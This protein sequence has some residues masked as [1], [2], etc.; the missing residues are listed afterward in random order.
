VPIAAIWFAGFLGIRAAIS[1]S[2]ST[3]PQNGTLTAYQTLEHLFVE[4]V[5][6]L[7]LVSSFPLH[8]ALLPCT[9][10][11]EPQTDLQLSL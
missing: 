4:S 2:P 7:F 11:A 9:N 6:T 8:A 10:V 5:S 1:P 3:S